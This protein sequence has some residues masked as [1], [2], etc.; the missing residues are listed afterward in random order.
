MEAVRIL[1]QRPSKLYK[2][3][4][5]RSLFKLSLV[6]ADL[7]KAESAQRRD[8]AQGLWNKVTGGGQPPESEEERDPLLPDV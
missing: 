6:L 1:R 2:S 4:L 5:G 8:E 7:G 3:R